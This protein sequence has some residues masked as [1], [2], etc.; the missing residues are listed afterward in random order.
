MTLTSFAIENN[1]DIEARS[2]VVAFEKHVK[3]Q[4]FSFKNDIL[5]HIQL[6]RRMQMISRLHKNCQ[7][8]QYA[9]LCNSLIIIDILGDQ[10]GKL[11]AKSFLQQILRQL[12]T[13]DQ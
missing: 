11:Y 6:T 10:E 9:G 8:S 12:K 5:K 1:T 7:K 13:K 4:D 3:E 2:F